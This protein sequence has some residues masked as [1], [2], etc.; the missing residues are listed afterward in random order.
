[1]SEFQFA[2]PT[3]HA[4]AL[5]QQVK[6]ERVGRRIRKRW[7]FLL[8]GL[9]LILAVPVILG[10][11]YARDVY[12][13]TVASG[14]LV[15][16]EIAEGSSIDQVAKQLLAKELIDQPQFFKLYLR[17]SGSQADIQA[18]KF[19]I[20]QF[21]SIADLSQRLGVAMRD[22]VILR[23]TEG[24]RR[25]QMAEYVESKYQTGEISFSGDQFSQLALH[26]TT[27]L[28]QKLGSRLP[29][30]ASLQGF[31]FPDTYHID[32]DAT[33]EDVLARMIDTYIQKVGPQLQAGFVSQGL[34]EYQ[35]LILAAIVEREA[36][37]GEERP[38]I[39]RI[40]LKR[41]QA[42]EILGTDATLQYALGYSEEEDRWWK[43]GITV[44]DL[45][46]DSPYNTR[47]VA[48]LPPAPICNPS[49]EAIKAVAEPASTPYLYYLHDQDGVVHYAETLSQHNANAA[50]YLQ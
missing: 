45:E 34:T 11:M 36:F 27:A 38:I 15:S 50:R 4:D 31:L 39:A 1:M 26:P 3:L 30:E 33:A 40:L 48:G 5:A 47:K 18:G 44:Q 19:E 22:Q 42:G 2:P 17:L 7:V 8:V 14:D 41:L 6:A 13:P 28:R 23:F 46:L 29:A 25:E 43:Q 16:L 49:I 12:Y 9:L 24:W 37:S 32:R 21:I 10:Y 35:A 20:P